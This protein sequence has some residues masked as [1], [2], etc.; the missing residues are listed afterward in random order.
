MPF[1]LAAFLLAAC[2]REAASLWLLRRQAASALRHRDAVPPDFAATVTAREHATAAD[3]TVARARTAAAGGLLDLAVTAAWV[4]GGLDLLAS[5]VDRRVASPL[6]QDVA[7]VAA[8]T[9]AGALLSLPLRAYATLVVEVRFGFNRT[10]PRLLCLDV[11]RGAVLAA[12][13]GLPLLAALFWVM[14]HASGAWWLWAWAGAVALMLCGPTIA[15]R[16]VMPLFNRFEPLSDPALAARIEAL[17]A[18]CGFASSGLFTM[19]ASRRTS[20]GNAFFTGFGRTKRIVLFDTLLARQTPEEVEAVVAHELGHFR[21]RHILFGMARGALTLL[22]GFAAVGWL[23]RQPWL[24]AGFGFAHHSEA[25]ALVAANL[26]LGLASPALGLASNALSR[27]HEFQAD[28]YA[29][30]QVGAAPMISALTKLSRDN[31]GTLTPD[32]LYALVNY[33]HPPVPVRIA[34]LRAAA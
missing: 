7:L 9:A 30:R 11:L 17:L 34:H 8:M 23:C 15:T 22:A 14:R 27:R 29:R 6:W 28:D 19:D 2:L 5:A 33:S 32:P 24:T 1:L 20:H 16:V 25:T 26:L 3:Y 10:T 18:R 21:H 31:A 12:A 13:F 4:L